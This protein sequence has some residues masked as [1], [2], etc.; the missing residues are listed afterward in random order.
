MPPQLNIVSPQ[1][2]KVTSCAAAQSCT[3]LLYHAYS[4]SIPIKYDKFF[5][6]VVSQCLINLLFLEHVLFSQVDKN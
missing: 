4:G 2:L 1:I 5:S 6:W 3:L